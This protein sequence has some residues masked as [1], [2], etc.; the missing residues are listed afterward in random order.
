MILLYS[1]SSVVQHGRPSKHGLY[2]D[3]ILHALVLPNYIKTASG[4]KTLQALS[5][6]WAKLL[7][8][9]RY[10]H[11]CVVYLVTVAWVEN[12]ICNWILRV[13]GSSTIWK[14]VLPFF[15]KII[16]A[17]ISTKDQMEWL[18]L[19]PCLVPSLCG[20]SRTFRGYWKRWDISWPPGLLLTRLS[21]EQKR[22]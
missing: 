22:V 15:R 11:R 6:F 12:F 4:R 2:L 19:W 13:T 21:P 10:A 9:V 5:A 8:A 17:R 16:A 20:A 7:L 1:V 18:N 14:S 3:L